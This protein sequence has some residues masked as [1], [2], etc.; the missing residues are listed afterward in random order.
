MKKILSILMS[1][2]L[3]VNF[4]F[5]VPSTRLRVEASVLMANELEILMQDIDEI[6]DT[7][8][9]F[10]ISS[11]DF[12]KILSMTD[13]NDIIFAET[14]SS[15]NA[16]FRNIQTDETEYP[17]IIQPDVDLILSCADYYANLDDEVQ[18]RAILDGN[19]P[20]NKT[21]QRERIRY[22]QTVFEKEYYQSKY[23]PI[24]GKYLAYLYTSHY[25]DNY[26]YNKDKPNFDNIMSN[27]ISK[28]DIIV[29]DHFFEAQSNLAMLSAFNSAGSIIGELK[30]SAD[31]SLLDRVKITVRG[32]KDAVNEETADYIEKMEKLGVDTTSIKDIMGTVTTV[33]EENYATAES[34]EALIALMYDNIDDAGV[35]GF[36][37]D[38]YMS[39]MRIMMLS[40]TF[41]TFVPG[42]LSIGSIMVDVYYGASSLAN[43]LNLVNTFSQRQASRSLISWGA[44]PR[45]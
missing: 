8:E 39:I 45:P 42:L 12:L 43:M 21:E 24:M 1:M 20:R 17:N 14:A 44:D 11:S 13:R 32:V 41:T 33:Y 5:L 36:T 6:A 2:V 4:V 30:G 10:G 23:Q 7:L 34:G 9:S 19:P 15:S 3:A 37:C 26:A 29:Y 28:E 35:A 31:G 27:I 22:I 38:T 16:A 40:S 18:T 25:I